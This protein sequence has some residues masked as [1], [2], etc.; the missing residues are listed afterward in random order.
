MRRALALALTAGWLAPAFPADPPPPSPMPAQASGPEL[1]VAAPEFD[2]DGIPKLVIPTD[3]T[4][5]AFARWVD[6]KLLADAYHDLDAAVL[7]DIALQAAEG[8]R[9]LLRPHRTVPAD[10]LLA[11]AARV[12]AERRDRDTLARL[13]AAAEKTGNAALLAKVDGG[14]KLAGT[15]RA[16]APAVTINLA[17][18]DP[19][20]VEGMRRLIAQVERARATGSAAEVKAAA[21]LLADLPEEDAK[22]CATL[23]KEIDALAADLAP[24]AEPGG[25]DDALVKLKA[26]ARGSCSALYREDKSRF[27]NG[28]RY[29]TDSSYPGHIFVEGSGGKFHMVHG[30]S[31]EGIAG[32]YGSADVYTGWIGPENK[33]YVEASNPNNVYLQDAGWT[34]WKSIAGL[35]GKGGAGVISP[36]ASGGS[37][38][39]AGGGNFKEAAKNIVAAGGGNVKDAVAAGA[40]IV[41]AGGGNI[42]A[43]GGGNAVP[44]PN[45]NLMASFSI[46]SVPGKSRTSIKFTK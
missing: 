3:L 21:A 5:P 27:P 24:A 31:I 15:A 7:A 37:I 39:A 43:A 35:I 45:G 9:V 4:D 8:E 13:R 14:M 16:S 32:R 36:G 28:K 44:G 17:D 1:V 6:L 23:R 29:Y 10:K 20:R 40:A 18:A 25:I 19:A 30:A 11:L 2:A 42:V 38:V 46:K 41:A 26:A 33:I 22:A 34:T 12:A